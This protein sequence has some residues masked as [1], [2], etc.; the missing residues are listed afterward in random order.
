MVC[1]GNRRARQPKGNRAVS[2]SAGTARMTEASYVDYTSYMN[3]LE[4]RCS[5]A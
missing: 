4:R 5:S 1:A 3:A 2:H